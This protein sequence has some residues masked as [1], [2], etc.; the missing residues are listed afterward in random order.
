MARL[1]GKTALVTGGTSG[2]GLA[3]TRRYVEEGAQVV[4]TGRNE[5]AGR[6]VEAEQGLADRAW[7]VKA[8]AT[9]EDSVRRSVES[10]VAR[11]G[12]LDILVN[13][14]GVAVMANVISTPIAEYDRV[15]DT[16][17]RGY[18]LYS[19]MAYPHLKKTRGC[20]IH[21]ASDAGLRGEQPLAIYSVSKAAVIML[22]KMLALDG[23]VDGV[24]SNCLC[25]T[26]LLPG[27]RHMGP[28]GDALHGDV[29]STWTVP[30]LGRLGRVEDVTGAAV[31]LA[32]DDAAFCSGSVLLVDGGIQAGLREPVTDGIRPA[33]ASPAG[34]A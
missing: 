2:L 13:N 23:G 11:L 19:L 28:P 27:M 24:R 26:S 31:F 8:D 9:D 20:M 21:I 32:G 29:P 3:I 10:A 22:A 14:A 15:M 18:Y 16:N 17:V 25:P 5:E 34:S 12:R 7:F 30:P 4:F 1:D 6:A 33:S